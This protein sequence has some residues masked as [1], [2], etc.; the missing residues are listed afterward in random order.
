MS[1]ASLALLAWGEGGGAERRSPMMQSTDGACLAQR[2][3]SRSSWEWIRQGGRK[4]E[5]TAGL[6]GI[7][8][9]YV[10]SSIHC[11]R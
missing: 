11:L 10:S 5:R 8:I 1:D 3:G 9:W 2:C 4:D 6:Y 7:V